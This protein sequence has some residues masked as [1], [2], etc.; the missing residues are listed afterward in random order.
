MNRVL[1]SYNHSPNIESEI[2]NGM[3]FP[4]WDV[5]GDEVLNE[6]GL[7]PP[8]KR[9]SVPGST[10][11]SRFRL[12]DKPTAI[13]AQKRNHP[14]VGLARPMNPPFMASRAFYTTYS[15]LT[16]VRTS[17]SSDTYYR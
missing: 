16:R 12:C 10:R 15:F 7:Q 8:F 4:G 11:L 9:V 6:V 3:F 13:S 2:E 17:P 14:V 5:S 1:K